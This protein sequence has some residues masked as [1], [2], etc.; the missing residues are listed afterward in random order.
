[1]GSNPA[2]WAGSRFRLLARSA[3]AEISITLDPEMAFGSGEHGSTRGALVLLDRFIQPDDRVLDLGTGSGILAIAAVKLG[4]GTRWASRSMPKR[5]RSRPPTSSGTVS[6]GAVT[7]LHGD[8][9]ELAPLCGPADLI[10]SNILRGAEHR[11]ASGDREDA[12]SRWHRESSRGWSR[13]SPIT[14]V[15]R[16]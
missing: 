9:A 10:V 4:P 15:R 13:A 1:M 11:A 14:S 6:A 8:A 2:G 16:C 12:S 5:C 3:D 7:L